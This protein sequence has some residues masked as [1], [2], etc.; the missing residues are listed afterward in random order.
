MCE[1]WARGA[2][3]GPL[4]RRR[5]GGGGAAVA[6]FAGPGELIRL[7]AA[8]RCR[9]TLA[10]GRAISCPRPAAAR[11]FEARVHSRLHSEC[12]STQAALWYQYLW[13]VYTQRSALQRGSSALSRHAGGAWA[14]RACPGHV[15][16]A[17]VSRLHA[18]RARQT[19]C[20]QALTRQALGCRPCGFPPPP[21]AASPAHNRRCSAVSA[22]PH[23]LWS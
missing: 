10:A 4:R 3:V 1:A 14:A 19:Q 7:T 5:R 18:M 8:T 16:N 17:V 2:A 11:P 23:T 12:G 6:G 22:L 15:K 9:P 21:I 13:S 20:E